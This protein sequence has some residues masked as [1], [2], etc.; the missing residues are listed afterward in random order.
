MEEEG[1]RPDKKFYDTVSR[2]VVL[3]DFNATWCAPCRA[4]DPIIKKLAERFAG[5]AGIESLDI[6]DNRETAQSLGIHSIPT[7]I[8]FKNGKEMQR[9]IGLQ[10]EEAL[11][12]AILDGLG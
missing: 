3:V 4:Q 10:S 12:R 9:F 5:K 1:K 8:L 11:S 7:L 6:D 2:G